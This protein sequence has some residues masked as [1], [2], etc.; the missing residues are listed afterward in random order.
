MFHQ[1]PM[2]PTVFRNSIILHGD[3][4]VYLVIQSTLEINTYLSTNT[5]ID[6]DEYGVLCRYFEHDMTVIS[7]PSYF[8]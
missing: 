2:I 8:V 4:S 6:T 7:G 1:Y 5:S 3:I